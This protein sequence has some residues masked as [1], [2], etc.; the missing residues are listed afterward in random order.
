MVVEDRR[1]FLRQLGAA[2]GTGIAGGAAFVRLDRSDRLA[3]ERLAGVYDALGLRGPLRGQTD[4]PPD[5][6]DYLQPGDSVIEDIAGTAALSDDLGAYRCLGI[7]REMRYPPDLDPGIQ[8]DW[9]APPDYFETGV[10]DCE[11]YALGYASVL[12]A[13]DH[14]SRFVVGAVEYGDQERGLHA[15]TETRIDGDWYVTEVNR[16]EL[17]YRRDVFPRTVSYWNPVAM[18]GVDLPYQVYDP[19]AQR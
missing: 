16:P 7:D 11:D 12:E 15:V 13:L 1:R 3:A 5:Y 2:A 8:R 17:L 6:M 10:G 19:A 4:V 9:V 14:P 18:F